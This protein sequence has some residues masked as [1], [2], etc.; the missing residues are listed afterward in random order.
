MRLWLVA[1]LLVALGCKKKD[2][3]E[4]PGAEPASQK[5][6]RAHNIT[7]EDRVAGIDLANLESCLASLKQCCLALEKGPCK[8]DPDR[9]RR[10]RSQVDRPAVD[11][12]L[13]SCR[14]SLSECLRA[15]ACSD[16]GV[17]AAVEVR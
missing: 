8:V 16:A 1:C 4:E 10:W 9:I 2:L 14:A 12:N 3:R 11:T 13:E 6:D 5:L 7:V 17:P 15:R